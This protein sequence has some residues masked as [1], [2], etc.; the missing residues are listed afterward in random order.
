MDLNS[1]LCDDTDSALK[2]WHV[3]EAEP[4][5][6]GEIVKGGEKIEMG[7]CEKNLVREI[8]G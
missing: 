1:P 6:E 7:R 8:T 2:A 4:A 3:C 5:E